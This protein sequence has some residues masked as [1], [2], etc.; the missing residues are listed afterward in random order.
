MSSRSISNLYIF[1]CCLHSVMWLFGIA[2][3]RMAIM[4]LYILVPLFYFIQVN[5]KQVSEYVKVH[6]VLFL[7]FFFYGIFLLISDERIYSILQLEVSKYMYLLKIANSLLPFYAFYA[8][9]RNGGMRDS[10]IQ[11]WIIVFFII[12]VL[13]YFHKNQVLLEEYTSRKFGR[14]EFTNNYGYSIAALIPV[15]IFYSKKPLFQYVLWGVCL[16]FVVMSVKRGAMIVSVMSVSFFIYCNLKTQQKRSTIFQ[17]LLFSVILVIALY[18]FFAH[19]W[20]SQAYFNQKIQLALD[21]DVNHR[22]EIASM[23]VNHLQ[24]GASFIELLFGGGAYNTLRVTG[25]L[26]HNDWLEIAMNQGALGISVFILYW[27]TLIKTCIKSKGNILCFLGISSFFIIFFT[28]TFFS[29]SYENFDFYSTLVL[30]YC[31]AILD[32]ETYQ[33]YKI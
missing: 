30:G 13:S 23:M 9:T 33:K 19:L 4:T 26:A 18:L 29:M 32:G 8:F 27:R 2:W 1:I 15:T 16:L 31:V 24:N 22:D 7:M 5:K 10:D 28:K 25:R 6:N 20:E 12:V 11:W 21:G 17:I 3:V 14:E